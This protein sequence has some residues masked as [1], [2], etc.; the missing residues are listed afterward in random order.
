MFRIGGVR[1]GRKSNR[2]EPV[3]RDELL[4]GEIICDQCHGSGW[5][6]GKTE[7]QYTCRKCQGDG[8]VDWISHIMGA[9]RKPPRTLKGT[10]TME[11]E[12]D[13]KAM[14]DVNLSDEIADSIIK[15]LGE[16]IDQEI[17]ENIVKLSVTQSKLR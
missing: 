14:Y 4:P 1:L 9:P 15:E 17:M 16:Q 7:W 11:V 2:K 13:L 8:K 5:I 3:S 10:W 6:T 12:Q